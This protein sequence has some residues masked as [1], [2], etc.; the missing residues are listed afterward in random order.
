M[1]RFRPWLVLLCW[2]A[3]P[4]SSNDSPSAAAGSKTVPVGTY[5][6]MP[7]TFAA[8]GIRLEG[9]R[10]LFFVPENRA[11]PGSRIIAVHFIRFP[12]ADAKSRREPVF[13]LPGGP[14]YEFNFSREIALR[15]VD[16]LRRTRDVVYVSQRGNPTA[17]AELANLSLSVAA[18]ALDAP[19]SPAL[20]RER[21]RAAFK[22]ALEEWKARGLDLRGYDILNVVD[23]VHELRAALGYD[24]IVL[25]GCSFGS[26]WSLSYLKR[27]PATVDRVLLSGVEPLDHAYDSPQWL[28]N[29]LTRLAQRAEA[30]PKFA[31]QVPPGGLLAAIQRAVERLEAKPVQVA[32]Q[33]P[34]TGKS[35][36][37]G[38][39]A[40]DLRRA[41]ASQSMFG[42]SRAEQ[43]ANWPRAIVEIDRGDYRYLAAKVWEAR[44]HAG[45][46]D[47][48]IVPLIDN[49]L[50]I[51]AAR[52]AKLLAE[53]EVRWIGDP[54]SFYR[55]TRDITPTPV[56][57]AA[58]RADAP[59][60]APVLMVA[61]D[62][63][64]STPVENARHLAGQLRQGHLIELQGGTHCDETDAGE[65]QLPQ[66]MDQVYGF[67]EADFSKTAPQKL[68]ATLPRAVAY[69]PIEFS[70]P[71]GASL[72]EGWLSARRGAIF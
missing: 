43:L 35:L 71:Q 19:D 27:W 24:K 26:Q 34:K 57:S 62:L 16:R 39:G 5:F 46:D 9:E 32:I 4:A 47:V 40:T 45:E 64:W 17:V 18:P 72:Y 61:G 63:D 29:S 48:L 52:D 50:G 44:T 36:S 69:P 33:D 3:L 68:F 70:V 55:N 22:Q 20:E 1:T 15:L 8:G 38:L 25:R 31:A 2:V 14:G 42:D 6:T 51:S 28:W 12:A 10:G 37:I 30:D 41:L 13:V 49:S 54:N 65:R 21:Q 67:I 7:N 60:T 66:L 59:I 53:P 11:V 58:F 23:D 56:V